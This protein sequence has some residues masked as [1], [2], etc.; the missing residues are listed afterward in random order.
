MSTDASPARPGRLQALVARADALGDRSRAQLRRVLPARRALLIQPYLGFACRTADGQRLELGGRVLRDP[1][2]RAP[3]AADSRWRNLIELYKRLESD[4]V[5]HA[6]LRAHAFGVEQTLSAD[7]EGYFQLALDVPTPLA[8]GWH[9]VALELLDPRMPDASE[10]RIDGCVR[11][12]PANARFGII[13]DIDDTVLWSNVRQRMRMLVL[14]LR[15][16]AHTRQPFKGV[17]AFYRALVDGA[18][19]AEGNP[20]FY[21]SSSPWNLYAPLVEFMQRQGIPLGP[22]LLKDFGDHTLFSSRDHHTHKRA[23]IERILSAYPELPFVLIGDSGEQD[24]EIYRQIVRDFPGRIR[25]VYIRNV[26]P[27]PNRIAA[28]DALIAEVRDS[29]AQLVLAADSEAAAAHAAGEG[30]IATAAL[31]DVRADRRR[32]ETLPTD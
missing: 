13:S 25:V 22:L 10:L 18:G 30:L 31:A 9:P 1:G 21:V 27:D 15:S 26:D 5:P 24:P 29:G 19:G 32:V 11:L 17:A 3:D 8:A 23:A 28:I 16:N 7:D 2:F 6:R 4:E 20:V 12:P 14:L